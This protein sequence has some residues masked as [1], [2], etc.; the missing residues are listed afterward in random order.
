MNFIR[1][2][3]EKS[4]PLKSG[5]KHNINVQIMQLTFFRKIHLSNKVTIKIYIH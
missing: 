2:V 4:L 3:F 5:Y 1:N